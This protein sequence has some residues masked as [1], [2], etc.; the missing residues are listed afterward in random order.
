MGVGD[1]KETQ[2]PGL[3]ACQSPE[4]F[5]SEVL[6]GGEDLSETLSMKYSMWVSKVSLII[7]DKEIRSL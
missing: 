4:R 5:G 2:E 3:S 6:P 7:P 1:R